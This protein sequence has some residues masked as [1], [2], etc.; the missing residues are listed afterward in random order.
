ME[1]V[2][3]E[4]RDRLASFA[5]SVQHPEAS[6]FIERFAVRAGEPARSFQDEEVIFFR[7]AACDDRFGVFGYPPPAFNRLAEVH[8]ISFGKRL[9]AANAYQEELKGA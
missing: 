4:E 7:K 3:P 1:A 9:A 2:A 6:K 8:D 5:H